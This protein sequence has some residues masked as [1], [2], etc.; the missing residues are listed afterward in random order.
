MPL[1]PCFIALY[2][3]CNGLRTTGNGLDSVQPQLRNSTADRP[4]L[5]SVREAYDTSL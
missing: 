2:L 1:T 3:E 4:L 5:C